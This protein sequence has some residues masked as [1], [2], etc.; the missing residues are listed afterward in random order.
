MRAVK[1]GGSSVADAPRLRAA[2]AILARSR[3]GGPVTAVVSAMAGVTDG[4]LRVADGATRGAEDW[5]AVL[6]ALGERHSATYQ[7][8]IGA[9]PALFERQWAEAEREAEALARI[10]PSLDAPARALA[11]ARFSGWG[12]RLAVGLLAAAT[13]AEGAPSFALDDAPVL[14]SG[15]ERPGVAPEP[16][17]LA[18]RAWLLPRLAMPV[19]RGAVPIVPGYIARDAEGRLTTLGRNGSDHSAAVIAAAL[20]VSHLTIYSDVAGVYTAD[21]RTLP[22]ARLLPALAYDEAA[23]IASLGAR[24]LHP[25]AVEPLAGGAIP[26]ELRAAHAPDALG[27]DIGPGARLSRQY[28]RAAMWVVVSRPAAVPREVDVTALRLPAWPLCED[29][30]DCAATVVLDIEHIEHIERF[31]LIPLAVARDEI[32][33]RVAEPQAREAIRALHNL[34]AGCASRHAEEVD[35]R[36][37]AGA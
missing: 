33:L 12:E 10:G 20:G 19:M 26:L 17:A 29:T 1:F 4:L 15:R 28:T 25:R 5:P 35:A 16:S 8:L 11:S 31:A 24:A 6:R 13:E 18:T 34:L 36:L 14:L 23:R 9:V 30:C 22:D 37:V 7:A 3:A 32:R 21:P 27:T 2:G